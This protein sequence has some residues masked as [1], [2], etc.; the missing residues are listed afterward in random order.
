MGS[1]FQQ[2]MFD[3]TGGY[4]IRGKE[5]QEGEP[6]IESHSIHLVH[7]CLARIR[8]RACCGKCSWAAFC[9]QEQHGT[10]GTT[11][12]GCNELVITSPCMS[13]LVPDQSSLRPI[14]PTPDQ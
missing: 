5:Y 11:I 8:A 1:I 4:L 2:A 14:E 7:V 13:S 10:Y 6:L 3:E 12:V 9:W